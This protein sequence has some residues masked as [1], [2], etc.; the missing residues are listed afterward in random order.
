[1][2]ALQGASL[3]AH[4]IYISIY[5]SLSLSLSFFLSFFLSLSLSLSPSLSLSLSIYLSCP[6]A[7]VSRSW[8]GH[9]LALLVYI[10]NVSCDVSPY[11]YIY[12]CMY[13]HLYV[14]CMSLPSGRM[15]TL[16][17]ASWSTPS[18]YIYIYICLSLSLALSLSL[19]LSPSSLLS[20]YICPA[21]GRI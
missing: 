1:M 17:G 13:I 9:S 12:I 6:W 15:K 19:S 5:L 4:Q 8:G 3:G 16:Q 2:K 14:Y 20:L 21:P 7:H 18:N 11:L 10:V